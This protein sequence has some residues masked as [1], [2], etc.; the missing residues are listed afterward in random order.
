MKIGLIKQQF[1]AQGGGSER[2]T[3]GL[4]AELR[5]RGHEVHILAARWDAAASSSGVTLHRVPILSGASFVRAL[6]FAWN[7]R[8]ALDKARC[9]VVLSLERTIRQDIVRAGGGCHREWL[10]QR[11][12]FRSWPQRDL[13]WLNPLHL[14]MLWIEKQTYSRSHTRCIIANSNRG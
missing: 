8:Q 4:V 13:L 10:I 2:Y 6:S 12:H 9:D 3:N 7:A 14:A 11:H 5:A 1:V